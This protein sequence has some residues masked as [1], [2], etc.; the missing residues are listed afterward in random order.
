MRD[1]SKKDSWTYVAAKVSML[2]IVISVLAVIVVALLPTSTKTNEAPVSREQPDTAQ[3]DA[4]D[5]LLAGT[6]LGQVL[7]AAKDKQAADDMA[8]TDKI[9]ESPRIQ[10]RTDR[11]CKK[12]PDWGESACLKIAK[13]KTWVGMDVEMLEESVGRPEDAD[14]TDLG[15]GHTNAFFFYSGGRTFYIEDGMV[16]T[17]TTH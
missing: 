14:V 15:G 3:P 4:Y 5:R 6:P 17:I 13:G 11:I 12:H 9:L 10:K 16:T 8:R 7:S 2:L 1:E